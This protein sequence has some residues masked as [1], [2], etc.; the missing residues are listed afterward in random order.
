MSV[1]VG[2]EMFDR[3]YAA[4]PDPWGY[5][6][7]VYEREKYTATLAALSGRSFDLA[8]EVGC[9]IGVFT[10][11]LAAHCRW[12]LAMDFS[13]KAIALARARLGS[14]GNVQLLRASFP[15]DAPIGQFDLVVCSEVLYYLDEQTL[16]RAMRWLRSQLSG[17]A[18][19]LAV[20]WRGRGWEE[21]L[22]GDDVHDLLVERLEP[23]HRLDAGQR[24]YRL[25][26]FDG[27]AT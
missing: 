26:R 22:H 9:S 15:E 13:P 3:K 7:S 27:D 20:S 18:T 10:E 14:L 12:L 4:S 24:G 17:G 11:L 6:R 25:D 1:R 8:L 5:E 16:L 23:W 2:A 19:V 21:P